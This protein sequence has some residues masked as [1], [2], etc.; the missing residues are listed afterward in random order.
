MQQAGSVGLSI[1]TITGQH[2]CG[3]DRMEHIGS[4]RSTFLIPMPLAREHER[5]FNEADLLWGKPASKRRY[6]SLILLVNIKLSVKLQRS[7][8]E[9][10]LPPLSLL[11]PP[12]SFRVTRNA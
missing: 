3:F 7:S 1:Q 11:A 5:S 4:A 9:I 6:E 10:T 8:S 12:R 2:Q